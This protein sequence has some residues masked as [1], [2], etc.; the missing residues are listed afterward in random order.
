M[1]K[2]PALHESDSCFKS[3]TSSTI[4]YRA[5]DLGSES[6][7][8]LSSQKPA[9]TGG[10]IKKMT[11]LLQRQTETYLWSWAEFVFPA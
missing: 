8:F 1:G 7:K 4:C 3:S 10:G 6:Q 2:K 9:V 11:A 5:E